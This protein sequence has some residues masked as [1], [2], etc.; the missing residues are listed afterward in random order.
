[1]IDRI[2]Y[3]AEEFSNKYIMESFNEEEHS[4]G[5]LLEKYHDIITM[6]IERYNELFENNKAIKASA[7]S[8]SLNSQFE[9]DPNVIQRHIKN[10][11]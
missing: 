1:M 3:Q 11:Q 7:A 6:I 8:L 9:N 2:R 5:D 4:L 10:S